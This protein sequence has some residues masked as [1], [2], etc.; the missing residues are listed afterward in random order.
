MNNNI[1][2]PGDDDYGRNPRLG[3]SKDNPPKW[4]QDWVPLIDR[5]KVIVTV[6]TDGTVVP[7]EPKTKPY[8]AKVE[9]F[10]KWVAARAYKDIRGKYRVYQMNIKHTLNS[11][12]ELYAWWDNNIENK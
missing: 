8:S 10:I 2:G 4:L 5:P 1:Y 6:P 11:L 9:R 7:M 3:P 12:D